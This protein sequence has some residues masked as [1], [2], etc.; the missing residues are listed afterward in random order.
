MRSG[1]SKVT[2]KVFDELM[3]PVFYLDEKGL[4]RYLNDFTRKALGF[5]E[6]D[7]LGLPGDLLFR[8]PQAMKALSQQV[9]VAGHAGPEKLYLRAVDGSSILFNLSFSE[10]KSTFGNVSGIIVYGEDVRETEKLRAEM[11][12]REMMERQLQ[13]VSE[14]LEETVD[15]Q[16]K[17]LSE[18]IAASQREMKERLKKEKKLRSEIADMEIMLDE[19]RH[20]QRKNM[21]LVLNLL[22]KYQWS[23]KS[24]NQRE[25]TK[26]LYQRIHTMYMIYKHIYISGIS[27]QVDFPAFIAEVCD[28]YHTLYSDHAN[29]QIQINT[30][31]D[32][33][34]VDQALPLGIA[35]NEI[36]YEA[37]KNFSSAPPD[38]KT[39]HAIVVDYSYHP[40]MNA[41]SLNISHPPGQQS[42]KNKHAYD[43]LP[44][45]QLASML[46]DDQLNGTMDTQY[47]QE[48]AVHI[49]FPEE[50]GGVSWLH[51]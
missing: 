30:D 21:K 1:P 46:I 43:H 26:E 19:I 34:P 23:G 35:V 41:Y 45:I 7:I 3:Q 24:R 44:G 10:L 18:R 39:R 9:D 33:L 16:T 17:K 11:A 49:S 32:D 47:H 31:K 12:R 28:R 50:K 15:Q 37:L 40:Q 20:R 48:I 51:N 25:K 2:T 38:H 8:N 27:E 42:A 6:H 5:D 14:S 22:N 36:L 13:A 29:L 4:I